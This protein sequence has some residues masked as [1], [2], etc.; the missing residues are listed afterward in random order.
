MADLSASDITS[1]Q[2]R[3][4][5]ILTQLNAMTSSSVGGNAN[6]NQPGATDHDAYTKRLYWELERIEKLIDSY[7]NSVNGADEFIHYGY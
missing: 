3:R 6:S 5:T 1:L 2:T 4:S 7:D